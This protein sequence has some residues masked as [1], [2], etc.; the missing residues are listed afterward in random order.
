MSRQK[1][2]LLDRLIDSFSL[3]GL[4]LH[5]ATLFLLATGTVIVGAIVL[6]GQQ[7]NKIVDQNEF[8]LTADKIQITPQPVWVEADLKNVV[9][10]QVG[11]D[12]SILDPTLVPNTADVIHSV[13]YI[14][15]VN[16]IDKS[17]LGL[18]IDVVYRRPVAAVELSEVTMPGGWP[19][20][21]RGKQ[22]LLPV[23]QNGVVMPEK[24]ATS[25]AMPLIN[26]IYPGNFSDLKTWSGWPD[27][28]VKDAAAIGSLFADNVASI[29]IDRIVT[30]RK[31]DDKDDPNKP[32]ILWS[33]FG[34]HIIW[35]NAPGKEA[36]HEVNAA[37][38]KQLVHQLIQEHGPLNGMSQ[39]QIDIRTGK[40][41][42]IGE[43]KTAST[44]S[45]LFSKLK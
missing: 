26:V 33:D 14:E 9:L 10:E 1:P 34:A 45:D 24:I 29:G 2:D 19:K 20:A 42:I 3:R 5:Q 23:D 25:V 44:L 43:M 40:A 11:T 35:G 30:Q 27:E 36:E 28:R 8:R 38:K 41:K 6:W 13:G 32:F 31:P 22:V 15:R 39:V 37:I 4:L 17:K 18:S 21:N 12:P 16:Q 7:R